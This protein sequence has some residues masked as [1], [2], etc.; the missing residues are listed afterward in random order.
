MFGTTFAGPLIKR[1][2]DVVQGPLGTD[3][4][5]NDYN[6]TTPMFSVAGGQKLI[7]RLL[8]GA[9]HYEF[10]S[11][12]GSI[13]AGWPPV[14]MWV[15]F[16]DLW[17]ASQHIISRSC[18]QVYQVPNNSEQET[19]DLYDAIKAVSHQSRVDHRFIL[20]A[21]MQ[22]TKGCVRAKTS[23]SPDGIR[24]PGLL[25]TFMGTFSCNDG[26][27]KAKVPCPHEQILGMISDGGK[28]RSR[29]PLFLSWL[30]RAWLTCA[31][32]S[33]RHRG[34]AWFRD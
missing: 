14:Q 28:W 25:Q 13:A 1:S 22:E 23:S 4:Y 33:G 7:L 2:N 30:E 8:G 29:A 9:N 3:E 5:W 34:R 24:N 15:S 10:Y 32:N 31:G 6:G 12:N 27:G 17:V 19:Q 26:D 16:N 18:D 21:V 11:G 20:A